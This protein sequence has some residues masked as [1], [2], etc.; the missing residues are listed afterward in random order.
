MDKRMVH[1]TKKK[2]KK[3]GGINKWLASN[4]HK[5]ISKTVIALPIAISL[6]YKY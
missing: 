3:K 2:K 6:N 5:S 1:K 4:H